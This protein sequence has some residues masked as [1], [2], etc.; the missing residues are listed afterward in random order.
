MLRNQI[1]TYL[2]DLGI[3]PHYKGFNYLVSALTMTVPQDSKIPML[4][5]YSKVAEE[6]GVNARR[7]ERCVRTLIGIYCDNMKPAPQYKY[8]NS[9]FLYLCTMHI[10]L[11]S[12][13][14]DAIEEAMQKGS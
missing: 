7:V 5:I 6:Y 8:T 14:A 11:G 9:E 1:V 13:E 2:L 4:E 3:R 10:K 12:G